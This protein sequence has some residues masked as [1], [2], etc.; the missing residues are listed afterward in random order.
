M[1]F[2]VL[3]ALCIAGT[4]AKSTHIP[5][6]NQAFIS[7]TIKRRAA[8][9]SLDFHLHV[10]LGVVNLAFPSINISLPLPLSP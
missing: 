5:G 4:N 8:S 10:G 9:L 3:G 7:H 6:S 1:H 2:L